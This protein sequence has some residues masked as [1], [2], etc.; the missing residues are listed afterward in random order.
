MRL[1][2]AVLFSPEI[3][4]ELREAIDRLRRTAV[5]GNFTHPDNLHMT[6][7]FIGES[8]RVED[9]VQ[10]MLEAGPQP[11]EI[12]LSG[13]GKFRQSGGDIVW[14]GIA[15]N[16]PLAEYAGRLA[17]LLR[18][19]G[20]D[21]ESRAFKPHITLGRQVVLPERLN[22]EIKPI[23]MR[24]G[25]ISLMRSDRPGGRLTYTEIRSVSTE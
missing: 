19:K 3:L 23:S 2:V 16:R 17:D 12:T 5:S 1:F 21:I 6:L 11:F 8:T 24:C 13:C 9:I 22:L 18:L 14:A 25:K 10:S 15:Q 4:A 7:A 20:F